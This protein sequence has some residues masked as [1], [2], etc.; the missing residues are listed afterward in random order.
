MK[1]ILRKKVFETNSS[2][3]H[4]LVISE[5]GMEES[6]LPIDEDGYVIAEYGSF[7]KDG[8]IYSSQSDKLSYLL[9][10]CYY[11]GG[12]EYQLRDTNNYHFKHIEEA[13]CDYTGAKGIKIVAGDPEIDHQEHP[14]Y[15]L[16]FVN[17][18][19]KKSIQNFVFNKYISL[20]CDCD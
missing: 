14:E 10:Q 11:L 12:W 8:T 15:E 20:L 7:G 6:N 9:T 4:S 1:Y 17:E 2:S 5:E 3:V 19:D 13:I 18:W 16:K